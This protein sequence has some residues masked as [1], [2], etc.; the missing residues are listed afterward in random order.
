M[1]MLIVSAS[2]PTVVESQWMRNSQA[3]LVAFL[4]APRRS[5]VSATSSAHYAPSWD[6]LRGAWPKNS[7]GSRGIP[8]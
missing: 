2:L 3:S 1:H 5:P 6:G 7:A 4:V 8:R